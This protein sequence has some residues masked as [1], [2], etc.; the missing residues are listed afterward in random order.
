[1]SFL[2]PLGLLGL[3]GIPILILVYII[4]SKYTEQTVAST[5]LWT[6]SERFLKRKRRP[7]PL[8]GIISLILQIL[9]VSLISMAVAHPII[10]VPDSAK[11]Y[12]FILDGS[13]SM[14]ME[15]GIPVEGDETV[16]VTRFDAA[17]SAIRQRVEEAMD[18]SIFTLVYAGDTTGVIC[19]RTEDKEQLL[20]L[21]DELIPAYNTLSLTDA[22]G[23]A[24]GY[25]NE[26]SGLQTVLF[27][28]N[29]YS[30][31]ENVEVVNVAQAVENYSLFDVTYTHLGDVLTVTGKV[32]S[33]TSDRDLTVNLYLDGGEP[34]VVSESVTVKA[35]EPS[36]FSL[37]AD[38]RAFSSIRALI[39][40]SDALSLDN[41]YVIHNIKSENS[42]DTL[43]V[44]DRPFFLESALRSQ[45]GASIKVV[46]PDE[47]DGETGYGLYV[48]DT[49]V[50]MGMTLPTDGTVWLVNV[51]GSIEGAG[52]TVQGE[53]ALARAESITLSTSS[54]TATRN[55]IE[56]IDGKDIYITRY[57]K[58]GFYR[59][60]TTLFSYKG[61]PVV[62]AGVT[63]YGNREVVVAFDLHDSNLTLLADFTILMKNLLAFS[64]PD[65]V[66]STTYGCGE[67][68]TVNIIPNCES[69]RVESPSGEVS[70]LKTDGA[71]DSFRLTEAGTYRVSITVSGSVREFFIWSAMS[72][73]ECDPAVLQESVA[74]VG[75]ATDGGFDGK[76]DPIW[77]IFIALAVVFLADWMVYCYE[78]YQLR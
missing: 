12:C 23:V 49:V 76:F 16:S 42:Y 56:G 38:V 33:H 24:Q 55:L 27:T 22:I 46:T 19:E 45:L 59:N 4:K 37:E 62:F 13:G 41:E 63:E 10:T 15:A 32:I 43:L 21:M 51:T 1:M 65:M 3:I 74:L 77:V 5:Y 26:N 75:E 69:I 17:K 54:A 57:V 47:Y 18:G 78:K 20:L 48:F 29:D 70:Y 44:S 35:G 66:E 39:V 67:S 11:E 52:Y 73:E 50:P 68:A 72:A 58:C 6:L 60:F 28:D 64:F 36:V 2:Y 14:R 71:T 31:A 25:F 53:M 34:P 30:S 8:A 9:A 61:S 40:E 7:S